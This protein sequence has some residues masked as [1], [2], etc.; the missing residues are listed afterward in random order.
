LINPALWGSGWL[1]VFKERGVKRSIDKW[2]KC[3]PQT[4]ATEQS[5]AAIQ[6]AF[7]DAKADILEL[8]EENKRLRKIMQIIAY[9]RRGTHEESYGILDMAKLI[10]SAYT[11]EYLDS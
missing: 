1:D 5:N 10:Q 4:M 2:K 3:N 7:E 11:A 9:P 8:H 6:F